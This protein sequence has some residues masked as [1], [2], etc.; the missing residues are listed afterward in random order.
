MNSEVLFGR[1]VGKSRRL[2]SQGGITILELIVVAAIG[3]VI[4]AIA[5]PNIMTV[6]YNIR[7]RSSADS[8]SGLL[9]QA[10]ILAVKTNKYYGVCATKFQNCN[11][12][13]TDPANIL[14]I[15]LNGNGSWDPGEPVAQ[16]SG[17]IT[18]M[19]AG[20]P[21]AGTMG[22]NFNP[23]TPNTQP[24]FNARGLPCALNG[25]TCATVLITPAGSQ[26][27]SFRMYLTDSRGF[28]RNGWAAVTV[29]PAGRM[30]TWIYTWTQWS[31]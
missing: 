26:I 6:I 7:L 11:K 12:N 25:A 15:D 2:R 31:N 14:Y 27:M 28:G 19:T 30:Q 24:Y 17:N 13:G 18:I 22:L 4:T 21:P 16:I 1:N 10:R 3:I 23:A 9:Q 5:V 29:S 8:I 20:T